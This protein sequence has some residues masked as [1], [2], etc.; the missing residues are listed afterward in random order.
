MSATSGTSTPPL[1]RA[2]DLPATWKYIENGLDKI[3]VEDLSNGGLSTAMYMNIYTAIHNFC[4]AH[5]TPSGPRSSGPAMRQGAQLLGADLYKNLEEYLRNHLSRLLSDTTQYVGDV[6][7]QHYMLA[8]ERYTVGARYLN[9]IFD[10][11]NRHWVKRQREEGRKHIY[12]VNT[13]CL[14]RWKRDLFDHIQDRLVDAILQEI[15][16]QRNG[17]AI[18]TSIA[19]KVIQSFVS[20]GLDETNTKRPSIIVYLEAFENPFI[21]ATEAYYRKESSTFLANNSVVDYMKKAASRLNEESARV[22]M[23]LHENT[24]RR[25]M[26]TCDQ[27]LIADHAKAMQEEFVTLLNEDREADF[28]KMYILL[29]RIKD[30][31]DPIQRILEDYIKKQGLLAVEKLVSESEDQSVDSRVYVDTL[32]SVH[33]KYRNTVQNAFEN[34]TE[35]VQSLD[36]GCRAFINTNIIAKPPNS[37]VRDS[38]TPELLAKYCDALLKKSAK[39]VQESDL[40]SKFNGIMRIFQYIDEK[41][42]FEKY[43]SRLLS[44]RLV[45]GTSASEDAETSMVAKLKEAC[46]FEYTN[47]LQRMFQ[48]MATSAEMQSQF[49]ATLDK[50]D[51]DF[52][53]FIFAESFWPLPKS[54]SEFNLPPQLQETFDKFHVFYGGKHSGRKLQWLWNFSKGE[55][56]AN[57][58]NSSKTGYIFQLSAYQMAIVLAYNTEETYTF[59]QLQEIT[60][61]QA[62]LLAGSLSFLLKARVLIETTVNSKPAYT[63]NYDFKNKKVRI[64]LNLPLKADLKR[65]TEDTQKHIEEDRKMF[66]QAVIVRIMKARKIL[67]HVHLVQEVMDQSK[68]RFT[69]KVPEI[70]KCIDS[71]IDKDYLQRVEGGKYQYLA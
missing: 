7:L 55:V 62:D 34:N 47:K 1:P 5:Q 35:L 3:M 67:R 25:L 51:T 63:L 64:N 23:Y 45:Y 70:K 20:L 17:E 42:V 39:N 44:K 11:V 61:L 66:L 19:K 31:L 41:D 6:L 37:K 33:T 48:D 15:E 2:D 43:Y 16:K 10:Y 60:A 21:A 58:A 36:N 28:H 52:S 30:G 68:K 27:V 24:E 54:K 18:N 69:P 59:D 49:K 9:H 22:Q 4:I 29:S 38:R 46:G 32:L 14:V 13:L 56:K 71:L 53:A 40:D 26:E 50:S 12:E 8:W 57:F 65:D